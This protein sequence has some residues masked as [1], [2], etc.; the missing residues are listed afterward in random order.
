MNGANIGGASHGSNLN[1]VPTTSSDK[2]E[3]DA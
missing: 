1:A 3:M 2:L